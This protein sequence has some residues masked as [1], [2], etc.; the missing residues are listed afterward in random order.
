M[1]PTGLRRRSAAARLLRLRVRIPQGAWM[2]VCCECCVLSSRGL[3]DGLITRPEE[4]YR[5]WCVVCDIETSWMRRPWP[6]GGR[7]VAAPPKKEIHETDNAFGACLSYLPVDYV[8]TCTL[9]IYLQITYS[10]RKNFD[11]D[12]REC[13]KLVSLL[14]TESLSAVLRTRQK[15]VKKS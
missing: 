14:S 10:W 8:F 6:N 3:C 1:W 4:S 15:F 11:F 13:A 5:L 2:S 12:K 7:G 9:P